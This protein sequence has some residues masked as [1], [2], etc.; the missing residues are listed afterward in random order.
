M[1]FAELSLADIAAAYNLSLEQVFAL[2]DRLSISY[3]DGQTNLAL[4]DAKAIIS[5]ILSELVSES[6]RPVF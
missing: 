3:K 2:C 6:G 1:G 4:E 5:L